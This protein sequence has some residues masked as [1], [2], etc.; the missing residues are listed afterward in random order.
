MFRSGIALTLIAI[1][2]A[3]AF[4]LAAAVSST[5]TVHPEAFPAQGSGVSFTFH[6]TAAADDVRVDF[7]TYPEPNQIED[8]AGVIG[9]V[10]ACQPLSPTSA[11]CISYDGHYEGRLRGG[12]DDVQLNGNPGGKLYG[13]DGLDDLNGTVGSE[14]IYGGGGND[15]INA[16]EGADFLD[17]GSG[18]DFING[19]LNSDKIR[20]VDGTRDTIDCGPGSDDVARI[21]RK[22][23][24]QW[25]CERVVRIR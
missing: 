1:V 14:E 22:I 12:N 24:H 19:G 5:A 8:P 23:D 3:V 4:F 25:G 7:G 18:T 6:G 9:A 15:R 11:E 16:W 21:D 10:G 17:G 20:A 13:G 2:A